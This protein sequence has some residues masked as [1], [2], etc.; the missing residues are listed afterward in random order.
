MPPGWLHR[1]RGIIMSCGAYFRLC[2]TAKGV[3]FKDR[4]IA[5]FFAKWGVPQHANGRQKSGACSVLLDYHYKGGN[6]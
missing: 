5:N 3:L 2:D 6:P 4:K 1:G